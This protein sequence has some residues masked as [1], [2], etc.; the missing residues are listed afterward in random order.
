MGENFNHKSN[1]NSAHTRMTH[2]Y[3]IHGMQKFVAMIQVIGWH[4]HSVI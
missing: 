3:G 2:Y 1:E 4:W